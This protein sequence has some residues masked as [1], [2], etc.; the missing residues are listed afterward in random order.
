MLPQSPH[1]GNL[2]RKA[3]LSPD[4]EGLE[5][6]RNDA[7]LAPGNH[8]YY[9]GSDGYVSLKAASASQYLAKSLR[10]SIL[11]RAKPATSSL[12]ASIAPATR[13]VIDAVAA[14]GPAAPA[15]P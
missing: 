5:A 12:Q 6:R 1:P 10:Q 7:A 11:F 14:Y 3:N 8:S 2:S 4:F 9:G 13:Q 15:W